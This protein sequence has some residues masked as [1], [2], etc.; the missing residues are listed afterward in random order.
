M[1]I[2][3]VAVILLLGTGCVSQIQCCDG[4]RGKLTPKA[5]VVMFD[6]LRADA[7][8]NS[9]ARNLRMLKEE[10][11]QD[12]YK[13]AWSLT[14][15]TIFDAPTISGPNHLAIAT[16]VSSAK[17][18]Q[19]GNEP[20]KCDHG[21][22]PSWLSRLVAAQPEKKAAFAY[23]WKWDESI[24]PDP[25]VDFIY[26]TDAANADRLPSVLASADA[27][28]AVM[29]FID[30]PDY[31]GHVYGYYP[32]SSGYFKT[33]HLSDDALGKALDAIASRPTFAQEDWLV[34]V[35]ADHGGCVNTHGLMKGHATTIP[36]YV[37]SRHVSSGRLAETLS[38]CDAAA[39]ALEHFGID[40]AG[41]QLDG[42]AAKMKTCIDEEERTLGDALAA[43]L[44]LDG[45]LL[46][47]VV[48]S[49]VVPVASGDAAVDAKGGFA[50]GGLRLRAGTNGVASVRLTGTENLEYEHGGDF[51][52]AFWLRASESQ[53]GDSV[54]LGNK[55]RGCASD[56]GMVVTS[57]V[58]VERVKEPGIGLSAGIDNGGCV[59]LAPYGINRGKWVFYAIAKDKSGLLRFYQGGSDGYLYWLSQNA[60]GMA[61]ATDLPLCLGQDGMGSCRNGFDGDFDDFALWTRTLSHEEIRRIYEFGRLGRPLGDLFTRTSERI[62]KKENL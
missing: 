5:L 19:Q 49:S 26:G 31:G 41:M 40:T 8:E 32:N 16:G 57:A 42:T 2:Y 38:D 60:P 10:R 55:S 44:P 15:N 54:I 11:W 18:G 52:I 17:T 20:N 37:C 43:Y 48:A 35:L 23:S 59:E 24:S 39:I 47:N 7:A 61:M 4:K 36:F 14:A 22:W 53:K 12:G 56:P 13:C 28:D 46:T 33:I 58:K 6:G 21:K 1:T 34:I 45:K 29:W 62:D 3:A 50:G 51:T 25:K 27:P 30:W 9:G